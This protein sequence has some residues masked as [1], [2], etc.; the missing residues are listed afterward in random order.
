MLNNDI[1]MQIAIYL[2][3]DDIYNFC[4]V[5]NLCYNTLSNNEYFWKLKYIYDY[6]NAD[7][8]GYVDRWKKTYLSIGNIWMFGRNNKCVPRKTDML[9]KFISC[10]NDYTYY[11]DVKDNVWV[12]NK[13]VLD[14]NIK[15]KQVACGA[16]HS[17]LI[18]MQ[19]QL[20]IIKNNNLPKPVPLNITAK[21]IACGH[22]NLFVDMD[23]NLWSFI[24]ICNDYKQIGDFKVK[25]IAC[26]LFH[27]LFIDMDDNLWSF[28]QNM[29]RQ[30]GLD[31]NN[32]YNE[33]TCLG[34]K[35]KHIACGDFHS[36]VIDMDNEVWTFG[37]NEC[38]QLGLRHNRKVWGLHR[39]GMTAKMIACGSDY[40]F[41]LDESNCLWAFGGN[42]YGQLGIGRAHN[43]RCKPNK[44]DIQGAKK[45]TSIDGGLLYSAFI[46]K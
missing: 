7:V 6:G 33:P 42:T 5:N 19:D 25:N 31:Y 37:N 9:A 41:V 1:I 26:G 20:W 28:G 11:I 8:V 44:V 24:D 12:Y 22:Y 2:D 27:C 40:S 16:V 21:K 13:N 36:V 23:D 38:G 10:N 30:L 35:V 18:D 29:H 4:S 39:L 45:I 14:L 32:E 46:S 15:A 17:L 34:V 3:V 43:Y